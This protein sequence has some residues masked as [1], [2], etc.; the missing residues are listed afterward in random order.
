MEKPQQDLAQQAH[1]G[2]GAKT[3]VSGQ[4][5]QFIDSLDLESI[6]P[7]IA[8]KARTCLL[9]GF[10]IGLACLGQATAGTAAQASLACDGDGAGARK[11]ATVLF[12]GKPDSLSAA[13][14]SNAVLLHSRCQEDTSGTAH[15]GVAVLPMA[16]ALLEAGMGRH[17]KLVPAVVAGYEVAGALESLLGR[18]TMAAGLRASPLYGTVAAAATAA[19][20]LGLDEGRTSAALANAAA[21]TGGT[22]QSIPE[23]SDEWRYQAGLAARNGLLAATL[24]GAGS[25]AAMRSFEGEQGFAAAYA[26]KPLIPG[27]LELGRHWRLP[28]V[29]FKPYPVCAHNQSPSLVAARVHE[30]FDPGDI[31]AIRIR[32]NPYI[33]PGML[34]RGPFTRVPET[35]MST[36]F[37]CACACLHGSVSMAR[38][39]QFDDPQIARM[40]ER[41]SVVPD[42]AVPFPSAAADVKTRDGLT[43]S[44]MENRTFSDFSLDR[45]AVK[46]QLL[47]IAAE[48][49]VPAKA[50]G[51]LEAFAFDPRGMSADNITNAYALARTGLQQTFHSIQRPA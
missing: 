15:L 26:R 7:E 30:S 45:A 3:T 1:D 10:G 18:D 40:M 28:T 41:I 9:Y 51:L 32:I 13:V 47:R 4:A 5:A 14:F 24:A 50:I 21:F 17:E 25:I 16:L 37:C 35:L 49:R 29:T 43:R 20:M 2:R 44:L 46:A 31:T 12:N 33:V 42:P 22:L 39:S 34:E 6:P 48:E 38:L 19:K 36:Y 8:D 23:G 11:K 27:D